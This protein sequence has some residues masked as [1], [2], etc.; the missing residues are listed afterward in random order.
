MRTIDP[1]GH[2]GATFESQSTADAS[3]L[4][5]CRLGTV[6]AVIA[7]GIQCT[8]ADN[9]CSREFH[10][11][12]SPPLPRR[13]FLITEVDSVIELVESLGVVAV[14]APITRLRQEAVF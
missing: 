8:D 6:A 2:N 13:N 9:W 1:D 11:A 10:D 12:N 3:Q 14:L 7:P 5:C 4:Q